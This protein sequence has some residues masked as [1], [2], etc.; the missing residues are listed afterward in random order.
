MEVSFKKDSKILLPLI[1]FN[2][3]LLI[4]GFDGVP[5][6]NYNL[7]NGRARWP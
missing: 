1:F 4:L 7:A 3:Y 5:R 6:D 2:I